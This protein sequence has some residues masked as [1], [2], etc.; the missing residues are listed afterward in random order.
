MDALSGAA[1]VIAVLQIAK[2]IGSAL[3]DYYEGVRD[4]REDIQKLYDTIKSLESILTSIRE[5]INRR[6]GQHMLNSGLFTD[7]SGPLQQ[8]KA[9]LEKLRLEL[10]TSPNTKGQRIL[11]RAIQILTWP[12]KK[13]DVEK[14]VV[15]IER[16]KSSLVLEVGLETL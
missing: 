12:F 15:A 1:S 8:C 9:E 16:H 14:A 3:K 13:S 4:A 6:D 10:G 5:I 11:G 7:A 2:S